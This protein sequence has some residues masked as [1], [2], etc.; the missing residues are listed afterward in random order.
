MARI[1]DY[2]K[3]IDLPSGRRYEVR[4]EVTGAD[5]KRRQKRKRF[6]T[7]KEAVDHYTA[8]AG[9]RGRGIHVAPSELT[10]EQAVDSWLLGQRIRPKTTSAYVTSLRPIVDHLGSRPVQSITKDDIETVVQALRTGTSKMGTWNAPTKLKKSAKKVRSK[11]AATSINPMLARTRAIFD[12]LVNQGIVVRNVAVL[13]KS[14]PVEKAEMH[15]LDGDQVIALLDATADDP[16]AIAWLLAVYGLR[17]GEILAVDIDKDIDLDANTI[18]VDESRIAVSGGSVT[19]ATKTVTSTRTLPMPEDLARAVRR[20][21]KRHAK[22]KLLLGSK[23]TDTGLLVV[24]EFGNPPHPD[25]LTAAWRRALANTGL[26]HVRLHDA[27]HSCATLMHLNRVPVVVI[28]AWLG[29]Q[30][31]GFTLRTYAHSTND[32]LA[33]AAAMLG[34]ITARKTKDAQ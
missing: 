7:L 19:G 5:G 8:I 21:R 11:W 26:P 31:P 3:V 10:V 1:P 17:R 30:D 28:A 4:P 20:E 23:W 2:V 18:R 33:E 16:F 13:V 27:R 32:A 29:H 14:L 6:K 12:D 22:L 9:D 34:T 25:T 24:D 15:T